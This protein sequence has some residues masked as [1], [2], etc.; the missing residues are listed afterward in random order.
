M[1]ADASGNDT[2]AVFVPVTG[3][4]CIAPYGTTLPTKAEM[5]TY[6]Y[7]PPAAWKR[8]GLIVVDG[9]PA[10][11]ENRADS[12]EFWQDSYETNAGTGTLDLVVKLAETNA[13][14]REI[15]RGVAPDGN[16]AID[17]DIDADVHYAIYVEEVG[18]DMGAGSPKRRRTY[19]NSWLTQNST[20]RSTRGEVNGNE[21]TFKVKRHADHGGKHFTEVLVP[22]D[23]TPSP[24][25]TSVIPSGATVGDY[26]MVEGNYLGTSGG[27]IS[28][29]TIDGQ[30]VVTKTWVSASRV[31]A[32]VPASVSGAAAVV[33]TT[34][35]G[36]A[37]NSYSYTAA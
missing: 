10:A 34:T 31:R 37:S 9:G 14:V 18:K 27:D 5:N 36:G 20:D 19:A 4:V 3:T 13:N 2:T 15:L 24:Y 25:I 21:A 33:L 26:V 28:A 11:T 8:A 32:L 12:I 23:A 30:A 1:A 7:T 6:G 16:N 35:S 29:F 22:Y 17:V